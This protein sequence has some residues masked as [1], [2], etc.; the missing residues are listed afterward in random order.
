MFRRNRK[1][2]YERLNES[3]SPPPPLPQKKDDSQ[4]PSAELLPKTHEKNLIDF[5][6]NSNKSENT[7]V[8]KS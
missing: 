6:T 5:S 4:K 3:P 7:S 1:P 2:K 8:P